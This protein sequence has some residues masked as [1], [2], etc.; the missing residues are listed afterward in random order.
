MKIIIAKDYAEMS[1]IAADEVINVIKKEQSPVLGLATGSTPVGTYKLL[2]EACERGGISF[3]NVHTVNLDEYV[4]LGADNEQSYI[5]FMC[6]NLFDKVDLPVGNINIPNGLAEDKEGECLRY[7]SL[8]KACRQDIQVLG[9]GSNG[10]IG[11][12]EPGTPFDS[13]THVVNLTQNTIKD[14]SRFFADISKVPTQAITMGIAEI[15]SAKKILLL[16]SGTNKARAVKEMVKGEIC[17]ACPA[18]ILQRHKNC[19][20]VVDVAAAALI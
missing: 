14:N 16:A 3:K 8:L 15:M 7:S 11:F 10:H 4:G 19:V 6:K 2:V 13:A 17:E 9:L 5:S 20:V 18:S 1:R 12:N